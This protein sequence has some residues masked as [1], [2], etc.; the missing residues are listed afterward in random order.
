[1]GDKPVGD[2][3]MGNVAISQSGGERGGRASS[4]SNNAGDK[5]GAE[6]WP[7]PPHAVPRT[8]AELIAAHGIGAE[9]TWTRVRRG[10]YLPPG[11][12]VTPQVRALAEVRARPAA[13]LSGAAAARAWGHPW[14]A[15][16]VPEMVLLGG[17]E[18]GNGVQQV[19]ADVTILR[20]K[21]ARKLRRCA[22]SIRDDGSD[23]GAAG[24]G[25]VT[26]TIAEPLDVT[27]DCV[28]ALPDD[29]AIAFLDGA[30]RAW[31]IDRQLRE[32]ANRS[33]RTGA[34]RMRELLDWTDWRAESR[35]ESLLRT[36]LR[37]AGQSQW[38]PQYMV[39]VASGKRWV[40]LGDHDYRISI[41][42]LGQG[43]WQDAE[44]RRA[45]AQRVNELR[46][47]GWTVIEVTILDVFRDFDALLRRIDEH[48]R[49]IDAERAQDIAWR[50]SKTVEAMRG[51]VNRW[52]K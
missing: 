24:P 21:P 17:A 7:P 40:D 14:V 15:N 39:L 13:V 6:T 51:R 46:E 36:K 11:T 2:T 23:I 5:A 22:L 20:R 45:D 25:E 31:G 10:L 32:W 44:S 18:G 34:K 4:Q 29:E 1:M 42:F 43:H 12:D 26:I 16:C 47:T 50:R 49:R 35:P 33:G 27:I 37:R 28:A 9:R 41:E 30:I 52:I 48:R 19:E 38:V 3:Q 8:R